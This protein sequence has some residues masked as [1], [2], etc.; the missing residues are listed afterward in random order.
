VYDRR[1]GDTLW[2]KHPNGFVV[3]ALDE[4]TG[5]LAPPELSLAM[6]RL[7]WDDPNR[8]TLLEASIGALHDLGLIVIDRS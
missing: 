2:L 8:D 7:G 3:A 6:A 4:A 1:S 5:G